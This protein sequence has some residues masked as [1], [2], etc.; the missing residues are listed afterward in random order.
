M[1]NEERMAGEDLSAWQKEPAVGITRRTCGF[2]DRID[3]K[4]SLLIR[5]AWGIV[6]IRRRTLGCA[7]GLIRECCRRGD[8]VRGSGFG[9]REA[10]VVD[11]VCLTA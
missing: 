10:R 8:T 2:K 7:E 4:G 5:I 9:R 1:T 11:G 6:M 3:A